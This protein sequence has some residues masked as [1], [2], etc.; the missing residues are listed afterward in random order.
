MLGFKSF[1]TASVTI[2]ASEL[3]HQIRKH[4]FVSQPADRL[5]RLNLG[6]A[7]FAAAMVY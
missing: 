5:E 4:Q 7:W 1:K 2:A 3:A 6:A